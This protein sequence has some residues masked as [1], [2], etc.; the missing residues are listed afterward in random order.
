MRTLGTATVKPSTLK[1]GQPISRQSKVALGTLVFAMVSALGLTLALKVPSMWD[2]DAPE[3][4]AKLLPDQN[5]PPAKFG[6]NLSGAEARGTDVLRPTIEDLR[7]AIEGQGF[8]LIR[9]PFK[10]DR[11]TPDRIRELRRFTDYAGQK[12]VPVILDNHSYTWLPVAEQLRWWADFAR[13]FPDDGSVLLD[14]NNEPKNIEWERWG[15]EAKQLIAGLRAEGLRHPIL[16]EWPGWSGISR[17]DKKEPANEMC[18]SA[19]CALDRAPGELDPIDRTF[20][21]GH[22][23]F[24]AD[25]S[26]TDGSCVNKKGIARTESGFNVFA[27]NLRKRGWKGYITESAFGSHN[28]IPQTCLAV[29]ADAISDV[30]ANRDTLL[31]ITWWGGGRLWPERYHFKIDCAKDRWRC[32]TSNYVRALRGGHSDRQSAPPLNVDQRIRTLPNNGT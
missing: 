3:A 15:I 14:L 1:K 26:G 8:R 12:G 31:G 25:G 17:F 5:A 7:Y 20:L 18:A 21:N 22:S 28:G 2:D 19:A 11:M 13:H 27:A 4:P 29:G 10:S 30:H 23:Y 9:Y 16:L 32:P 24:D 6:I